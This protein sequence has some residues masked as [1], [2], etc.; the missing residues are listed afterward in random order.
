MRCALLRLKKLLKGRKMHMGFM[1]VFLLHSGHRRVSATRRHLQGGE[2]KNTSICVG[3]TRRLKIVYF[4]LKF[5][6]NG[7]TPINKNIRS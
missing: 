6:L 1:N 4:C 5:R 3:I 2:N 7:E